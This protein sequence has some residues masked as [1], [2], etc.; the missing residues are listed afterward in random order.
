MMIGNTLAQDVGPGVPA[1]I[2]GT[3]G[4]AGT[5]TSDTAPDVFW[6]ADSP[7]D[8]QAEANTS[9]TAAQAR[10]T[11]RLDIP[12]GATV[13]KAYLYAAARA[14]GGVVPTTITLEVPGVASQ[15]ITPV[16]NSTVSLNGTFYQ[17]VSD[18]TEFVQQH[19]SGNYRVS[20][21]SSVALTNLN[22]A[23]IAVGWSMVIVYES[24]SEPYRQIQ[25][26]DGLRL[27]VDG[28]PATVTFSGLNV[29]GGPAYLG[30]FAMDG[31]DASVG[32]AL[33][34]KGNAVSNTLN[35]ADNFFNSTRSFSG[36]AV[37]VSGDLPRLTGT[38]RS[39]SGIDLDVADITGSLTA[40]DVS[41]DVA[42]ETTGDT[43]LVGLFVAGVP[44]QAP[45]SA[46]TV[47]IAATPSLTVGQGQTLTL[48]ASGADSYSWSGGESTTAISVSASGTYAVTGITG[49]NS[50]TAKVEATVLTA[51][52]CD[53]AIVANAFSVT[54]TAVLGANA[55]DVAVQ[56]TG[57]G[58]SLRLTGPND[59]VYS[60][61]YRRPGNYRLNAL[62]IRQPGTYTFTAAYQDACGQVS[63]Q[64]M[65]YIVTGTACP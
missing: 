59:Y 48:T 21:V 1:P 50:G 30:V 41:F 31:D 27:V 19:G 37:S 64:T 33:T 52:P 34:V 6:R 20:G 63:T 11:A 62:A 61:V 65:T 16:D 51:P 54:Q 29:A 49:C 13:R 23:T 43:Y 5:N 15:S 44:A 24:C 35:P 3:V 57:F 28:A 14:P 60:T 8:G 2:V 55:C 45:V 12:A 38:A 9:I 42:A 46:L 40:G 56:A 32:D 7:S 17:T 36:T 26:K 53:P 39:M 58:T 18:V 25:I 47:S 4:A 10:T 22:D